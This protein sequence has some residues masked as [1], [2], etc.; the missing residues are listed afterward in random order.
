MVNQRKIIQ[1]SLDGETSA[2]ATVKHLTRFTDALLGQLLV[3]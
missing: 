2:I 1:I 3:L